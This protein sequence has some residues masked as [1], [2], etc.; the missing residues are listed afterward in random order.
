VTTGGGGG[1]GWDGVGQ[2]L[3]LW[4]GHV[5]YWG[6][7]AEALEHFSRLGYE[8]PP[9]TNP[10]EFILDLVPP[11]PRE[12]NAATDLEKLHRCSCKAAAAALL[13]KRQGCSY[14]AA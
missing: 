13:E 5:V 11:R 9:R 10:A 6:A 7:A 8:C 3:V 14:S 2:L 1:V 12:Q 4:E